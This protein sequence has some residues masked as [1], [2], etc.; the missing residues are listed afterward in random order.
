MGDGDI[1]KLREALA[2]RARGRGKRYTAN[3]RQRIAE[4]ATVLRGR[5]HGWHTIVVRRNCAPRTI[6]ALLAASRARR[7]RRGQSSGWKHAAS[8]GTHPHAGGGRGGLVL[9]P[10]RGCCYSLISASTSWVNNVSDSCHPR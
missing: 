6:S 3:L 7:G 2:R 5:G 8:H 4:A 9:L 1:Q 10:N